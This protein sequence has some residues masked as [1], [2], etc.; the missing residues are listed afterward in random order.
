MLEIL[1]NKKVE[2]CYLDYASYVN[3]TRALPDW[4]DGLKSVQRRLL[5]T[6]Y[7]NRSSFTKCAALVGDCMRRYHPHGGDSIYGTLVNLVNS[8]YPTFEGQG[9][10]GG[11]GE[12]A[13]AYRYTEAR[14]SNL[15]INLYINF[16]K[17]TK[18]IENDLGNSEPEYLPTIIPYALISKCQGIGVGISTNM[19]PFDLRSLLKYAKWYLEPNGQSSP[20]IKLYP[21]MYSVNGDVA[22]IFNNGIGTV[23][24]RPEIL[25]EYSNVYGKYITRILSKDPNSNIEA[26]VRKIF[27][28]ELENDYVFM[29]D[30]TTDS[31]NIIIGRSSYI[32]RI[33]D[34]EIY[35]KC[36]ERLVKT[37][38]VSNYWNVDGISKRLS[39]AYVLN[40]ACERFHTYFK[41]SIKEQIS[42]LDIQ[43]KYEE[44]KSK[45]VF[46]KYN[47]LTKIDIMK[48]LSLNEEEYQY[49]NSRTINSLD[50]DN[51]R[52][53]TKELDKLK[54]KK[55][56]E[57]C[58]FREGL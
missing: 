11:F 20:N 15:A 42:K 56:T 16:I 54:N 13:A 49:F 28:Y 36:K 57:Y 23:S 45:F 10:F 14:L 32:K 26:Y 58:Y 51:S 52:N 33:S 31:Y 38:T 30:E 8:V 44:L 4:R 19:V 34:E 35:T 53:L 50:L 46:M 47:K 48:E 22:G 43:L 41:D 17:E 55:V 2:S 40:S 27:A 25:Y 24:Y 29:N 39:V 1:V 7:H 6:G 3:S 12:G 21:L 18:Y 37:I 9:N 5:I